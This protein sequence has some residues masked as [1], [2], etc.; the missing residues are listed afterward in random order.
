MIR[1]DYGQPYLIRQRA[2]DRYCVHNDPDSRGCTVHPL[3]PRV[4]RGYDCRTDPRVWI[5]YEHRIVAPMPEDAGH[6]RGR[7]MQFDLHERAK[8]RAVAVQRE[9]RAINESFA[10]G[11]PRKGPRP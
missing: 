8:A 7:A 4:C 1:W 10:D 9:T 11:S 3:R 6:D 2:S 5:D